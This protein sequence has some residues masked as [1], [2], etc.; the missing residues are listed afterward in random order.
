VVIDDTYTFN[1][2]GT[3]LTIPQADLAS[4]GL[5]HGAH[6]FEIKASAIIGTDPEPKGSNSIVKNVIFYDSTKSNYIIVCDFFD[7]EV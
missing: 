5:T 3:T 2:S 4:Y 6:K 1:L 7:K